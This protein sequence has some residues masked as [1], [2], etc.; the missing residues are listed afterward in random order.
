[1]PISESHQSGINIDAAAQH[2]MMAST[3]TRPTIT[4]V[5]RSGATNVI[6]WS[7]VSSQGSAFHLQK[8]F[9]SGAWGD[10]FPPSISA[11]DS[12]DSNS[13]ADGLYEY[14]IRTRRGQRYSAWSNTGSFTVTSPTPPA[15]TIIESDLTTLGSFNFPT[16]AGGVGTNF[17]QAPLAF[18]NGELLSITSDGNVG[19]GRLFQMTIPA[20]L[21]SE[22]Y[23]TATVSKAFGDVYQD[24][25][26]HYDAT[27]YNYVYGLF[28]D[29][30]N[31]NN[32]Y[33]NYG[34]YYSGDQISPSFLKTVLNDG[35]VT[36]T[37]EAAWTVSGVDNRWTRGGCL[38]MP[39]AFVAAHCPNKPFLVG[40]GGGWMANVTGASMGP[41][42]LAVPEPSVGTYAHESGLPY[43]QGMG[44]PYTA[45]V[46]GTPPRARRGDD[47][48]GGLYGPVQSPSGLTDYLAAA[49]A[50]SV[51]LPNSIYDSD[52]VGILF[53]ITS[54]VNQQTV[55]LGAKIGTRKFSVT[56]TNGTPRAGVEFEARYV[57]VGTRQ[58][59]GEWPPVGGIGYHTLADR[60]R[61]AAWIR[62]TP[63]GLLVFGTEVYGMTFYGPGGPHY[64][65]ARHYVEVYDQANI[66]SVL[67]GDMN[68][69]DVDPASRWFLEAP[70]MT[71][72]LTHQDLEYFFFSLAG[73]AY[74]DTNRK[75]YVT[76]KN[77]NPVGGGNFVPR[78]H[79]IQIAGSN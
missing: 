5:L 39:A 15:G 10:M 37:A 46:H 28:C 1:M 3:I 27:T 19:S 47:Y 17:S 60:I 69:Y 9:A 13:T 52:Y 64:Q 25:R 58:F 78:V 71:Y 61:G 75:L 41:C 59:N 77:Q 29:P 31:P 66:A 68:G 32:L 44:Y 12:T 34:A 49:D 4:S 23:N 70:G 7:V 18:R 14:R 40:L 30:D 56:W 22:P 50:S 43:T 48:E 8:R 24:K 79:C 2:L 76:I 42:F 53:S 35:A 6:S 21:T 51:T 72:P 33:V 45:T 55:T 65:Y 67:D 57:P 20:L 26:V 74:D 73:V 62:G 11:R 63:S 36:G 38:R 54:G 16:T